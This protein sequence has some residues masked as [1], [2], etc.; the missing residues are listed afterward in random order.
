M[1]P[2]SIHEPFKAKQCSECHV[3]EESNR[4]KDDINAACRSC[5]ASLIES[6]PPGT[7]EAVKSGACV[8]CHDPH[9]SPAL[10]LVRVEAERMCFKCHSVEQ[11]QTERHPPVARADCLICHA[12]H[13]SDRPHLLRSLDSL[14]TWNGLGVQAD[15]QSPDSGLDSRPARPVPPSSPLHPP[16]GEPARGD[17]EPAPGPAPA[18]GRPP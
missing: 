11:I 6:A 5:H 13:E 16:P 10:H 15:G 7:H 8:I 1:K 14:R 12:G 4:I 17:R 18:P 9:Q 3:I 2:Q